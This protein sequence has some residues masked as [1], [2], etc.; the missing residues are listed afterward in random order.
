MS[1]ADIKHNRAYRDG[2]RRALVLIAPQVPAPDSV[3]PLPRLTAALQRLE[4]E[5]AQA[6]ALVSDAVRDGKAGTGGAQG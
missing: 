4:R 2:L 6:A 5:V 1:D 3:H